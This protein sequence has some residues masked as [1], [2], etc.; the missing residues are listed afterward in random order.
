MLRNNKRQRKLVFIHPG[1]CGGST[2]RHCIETS[3]FR[4]KYCLDD[5]GY[6]HSH[7]RQIAF[8]RNTDYII[9]L[10]N[11]LRRMVSAWNWRK[12]LVFERG[13]SP[14]ADE[15]YVLK[16]FITLNNLAKELYDSN[17]RVNVDLLEKINV[18]GHFSR[19]INFHLY[20]VAKHLHPF[21]SHAI[22][23][24]RLSDDLLTLGMRVKKRLKEHQ[25]NVSKEDLLLEEVAAENLVKA[26]S[27]EYRCIDLLYERRVIS[28]AQ[29][30]SLSSKVHL[31]P[32]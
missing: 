27:K 1:K 4:E 15:E 25:S 5:D 12:H 6:T 3:G 11:P 32:H 31:N 7:T 2:I 24:E 10:R 19:G 8:R 29:Y 21:N 23:Q 20:R 16:E 13:V 28:D 30:A 17:G 18:V 9:A 22:C 14:I 26:F